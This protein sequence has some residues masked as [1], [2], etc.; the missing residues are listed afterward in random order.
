[1][2]Q[3]HKKTWLWG[4]GI[5]LAALLALVG[6]LWFGSPAQAPAPEP[7][8]RGGSGGAGAWPHPRRRGGGA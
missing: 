4:A 8:R 1:M 7:E 3:D 2:R 6:G 5:A